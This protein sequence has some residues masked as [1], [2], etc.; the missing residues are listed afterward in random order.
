MSCRKCTAETQRRR[1]YAEKASKTMP[2]IVSKSWRHIFAP[3][4]KQRTFPAY[5]LDRRVTIIKAPRLHFATRGDKSNHDHQ[6]S[7]QPNATA[8]KSWTSIRH[9]ARSRACA[10]P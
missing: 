4:D 1:D 6:T 10:S 9:G 5:F 3:V 7:L 8:T 2:S